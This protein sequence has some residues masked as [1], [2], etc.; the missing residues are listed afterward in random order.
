MD[1]VRTVQIG[2]RDVKLREHALTIGGI[3]VIWTLDDARYNDGT[4]VPDAELKAAGIR[5]R[6]QPPEGEDEDD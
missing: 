4:R 2:D 6:P 5:H 3:P 1:R